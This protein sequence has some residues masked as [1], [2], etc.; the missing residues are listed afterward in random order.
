M[1]TYG[2][3]PTGLVIPA[4]DDLRTD[5]ETDLRNTFGKGLPLGDKTLLGHIIGIL[6]AALGNLWSA[7]EI[8]FNMMDPDKVSGA[9]LDAICLLTGTFRVPATSSVVTMTIC[10]NDSTLVPSLSIFAAVSNLQQYQTQNDA[11]I[12]EVDA[13]TPS[14]AYVEDDRVGNGG[15]CYQCTTGGTSAGSGGPDDTTFGDDIVDG[16]VHWIWIGT[17]A[18]AVDV[19]A[20]ATATGPLFNPAGDITFQTNPLGGIDSVV[21]LADVTPGADIQADQDLRLQR[22]TDLAKSG[23]ATPD[24]VYD[25]LTEVANVVSVSVF[26]NNTETYDPDTGLPPKT[27]KALVQGGADQDIWNTLWASVG[28]G[29]R[30]IGDQIGT[31]VDAQGNNQTLRF[32]RPTEVPIYIEVH[33]IVNALTFPGDGAVEIQDAIV[34]FGDTLPIGKDAVSR[35]LGAQAFTIAGVD[36]V[37]HCYISTAPSPTME[38]TITIDDLSLA[39]YSTLNIAVVVVDGTP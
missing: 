30:T 13:W 37:P 3:T 7:L 23:S 35:Q 39:T 16:T 11:I 21:N 34:T 12:I 32:I 15:Q 26:S 5:Y 25:N 10:G 22:E 6:S 4:A 24:A 29:I 19:V 33:V 18:G 38:T 1:T 8:A 17:G 20:T 2:V 31:V 14:T 36:D 27:V 9:L 28:L